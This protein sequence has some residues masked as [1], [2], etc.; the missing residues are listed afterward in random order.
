M[1]TTRRRSPLLGGVL[2]SLALAVPVALLVGGGAVPAWAAPTAAELQAQIDSPEFR[3]KILALEYRTLRP[4]TKLSDLAQLDQGE[5]KNLS[6]DNPLNRPSFG[7]EDEKFT[8]TP[9]YTDDTFQVNV[10]TTKEGGAKGAVGFGLSYLEKKLNDWW[11]DDRAKAKA[12]SKALDCANAFHETRVVYDRVVGQ[13]PDPWTHNHYREVYLDLDRKADRLE[14]AIRADGGRAPGVTDEQR[15]IVWD[16]VRQA[17]DDYI[18]HPPSPEQ[19]ATGGEEI[20]KEMRNRLCDV[21]ERTR[22]GHTAEEWVNKLRD[23]PESKAYLPTAVTKA[24]Q[25]ILGRDPDPAGLQLHVDQLAAKKLT[26]DEFRQALFSSAEGG[27]VRSTA[28]EEWVTQAYQAILGRAPDESGRQ[29][30]VRA[31]LARTLT[32]EQAVQSLRASDEGVAYAKGVV[33]ALYREL[34]GREPDAEGLQSFVVGLVKGESSFAEVAR[35]LRTSTEGQAHAAAVVA[36]TYREVVGREPDA[37]GAAAWTSA[38]LNGDLLPSELPG[39]FSATEEGQVRVGEAANQT[40]AEVYRAELGREPSADD[41]AFWATK[42][43]SGELSR[44]Q[45]VAQVRSSKEYLDRA[46]EA[47]N[48]TVAEVYR[49]VLGREPSAEDLAYWAPRLVSG[50]LDRA[51]LTAQVENSEEARQRAGGGG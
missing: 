8:K 46:G 39:K 13:T 19:L 44:E 18:G 27:T 24:Y 31:L 37:A 45:L 6:K 2:R 17:F 32:P 11:E 50:E 14:A 5:Q 25:Q 21:P 20:A 16:V 33:V 40:V 15:T 36:K 49:T 26:M 4:E 1:V 47:A 38:L 9:I 22:A 10:G 48:Q 42:V 35:A 51:Q 23:E 28:A 29:E 43:A 41:L 7:L 12:K 3:Q 34:L 30:Y